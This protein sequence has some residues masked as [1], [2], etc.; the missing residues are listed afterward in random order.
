M[1]RI[2]HA[3]IIAALVLMLSL[4]GCTKTWL[5]V[6]TE[7]TNMDSWLKQDWFPPYTLTLHNS[8]MYLDG[9]I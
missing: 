5:V 4:T 9:K 6:F 8:G 7:Y 2:K 3:L 1:K